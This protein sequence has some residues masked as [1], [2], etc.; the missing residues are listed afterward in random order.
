MPALNIFIDGSW[1]F[2]Q[3]AAD[4]SL[5]NA[6]DRPGDH[7][8]LDFGRLNQE[9]LKHVRSTGGEACELGDLI[10]SISIFDLPSDFDSWPSRVSGMR[11]EDVQSIRNGVWAREWFVREAREAG[12]KDDAVF[13]LPVREWMA[14]RFVERRYQEKQVDTTLVALL[15]R[16]AITRANDFHAVITGD[17]DMLPAIKIAYPEFTKNV[18]VATTH[19]DELDSRHR[20]T[21][22]SLV[23]IGFKIPPYFMQ[24]KG[25]AE[26]IIAGPFPYRCEECGRVFVAD[27][28][29][30][31]S[32]RPRCQRCRPYG[33]PR[34]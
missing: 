6:T 13:R 28:S 1:L 29:I 12:Y 9:L 32:Q 33:T 24:N 18:F 2:R 22:F 20:Q 30:Q 16:A 8:R 25:N 3:C 27:N 19:P 34:R 31:Q 7:F 10:L 15:V 23:E 17:A 26:K 21:A 5:A 4:A 11:P 14:R